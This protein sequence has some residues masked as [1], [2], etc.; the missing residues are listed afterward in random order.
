MLRGSCGSEVCLATDGSRGSCV[1]QLALLLRRK[2]LFHGSSRLWLGA[3]SPYLR[4]RLVAIVARSRVSRQAFCCSYVRFA[5]WSGLEPHFVAGSGS[6]PCF[7]AR[8]CLGLC[9]AALAHLADPKRSEPRNA[10][11][12]RESQFHGSYDLASR[13]V[14]RGSEQLTAVSCGSCN[15]EPCVADWGCVSVALAALAG[16]RRGWKLCFAAR[17]ARA[18]QS[19]VS[20]HGTESCSSEIHFTAWSHV[21]WLI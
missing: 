4:P 11:L 14:S 21:S 12:S 3:T 1:L 15:S 9:F 6:G 17:A 16:W 10:A 13:S 7:V 8:S 18:A 5:D 2:D 19:F 20:Q